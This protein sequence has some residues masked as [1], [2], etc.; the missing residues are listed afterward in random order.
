MAN[1]LEK[2]YYKEKPEVFTQILEGMK[3]NPN[4]LHLFSWTD[5]PFYY[6]ADA[7]TSAM[8]IQ[9][10]EDQWKFDSLFQQFSEFGKKQILQ[11]VLID[12]VFS[13][14][15][16]EQIFS[17]R[18][19][20]FTVLEQCSKSE[21]PKIMSVVNGY[22]YL[23]EEGKT[24]LRCLQDIRT[25]YDAVLAETLDSQDLPDGIWFRKEPVQITNGI[26]TIH[27]GFYP[28]ES[29]NRGMQEYLDVIHYSGLDVYERMFLGHFLLEV[30]HPYY[31]G[32]GRLG[33]FLMTAGLYSETGS[34]SS[35]FIT[36]ALNQ[37]RSKYYQALADAQKPHQFGFLNQY[38]LEIGNLF[39]QECQKQITYLK[40]QKEQMDRLQFDKERFTKSELRILR[41][42]AEGTLLSLY[43]TSYPEIMNYA[44][45]SKR[46]VITAMNKLHRM[47]L[48]KDTKFGKVVYHKLNLQEIE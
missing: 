4:T 6:L 11:S 25:I 31:D 5:K 19:D 41:V 33:R 9:L 37:N 24:E 46:T 23:L 39:H 44:S 20:I 47:N 36:T 14:N 26:K 45:V 2:L 40:K 34:Y 35:F 17:T 16:I 3:K 12:E 29:I 1:G 43:G 32:N 18:H 28:E 30:I 27:S 8:L 42:L 13:T 15:E 22:R 10:H 21:D 7:D 38:V 48:L